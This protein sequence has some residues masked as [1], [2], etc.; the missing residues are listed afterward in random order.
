MN[1][2]KVLK[3]KIKK[4]ESDI[5]ICGLGVM[6]F[7]LW[8]VLKFII[9]MLYGNLDYLEEINEGDPQIRVLVMLGVAFFVSAFILGIHTYIALKAFRYVN[10]PRRKKG[11]LVLVV[12]LAIVTA[13]NIPDYFRNDAGKFIIDDTIVAAALVDVTLFYILCDLVYSAIRLAVFNKKMIQG[14]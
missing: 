10:G 7:G 11:F 9:E 1:D 12:I 5:L 2:Q 3:K 4:C 6:V 8:S 13:I 14:E